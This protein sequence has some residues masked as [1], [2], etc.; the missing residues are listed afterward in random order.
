MIETLFHTTIEVIVKENEE[1]DEG[2]E[3]ETIK[4]AEESKKEL[5]NYIDS[6]FK[7]KLCTSSSICNKMF[8][9]YVLEKEW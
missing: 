2:K 1:M 7:V 6:G 3:R 5:R 4:Q 9:H 8:V